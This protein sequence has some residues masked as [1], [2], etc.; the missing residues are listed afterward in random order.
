MRRK[1]AFPLLI[2]LAVVSGLAPF[3]MAVL[4]PLLPG[5]IV[6]FG[7]DHAT[8]QFVV[9][10]YLLGL[11]LAQPVAGFLC[12]L[13][14]R[15]IVVLVGMGIFVFASIACAFAESVAM[16]ISLRFMQAIG[17]STGTVV[18]RAVI[19]DTHDA[20]VGGRAMSYLTIG[21]GLAPVV[22]PMLS[23]LMYMVGGFRLVFAATASVGVVVW[24][25]LW[26]HLPETR[27]PELPKPR[28]QAWLASY[29]QLL[30]SP[31]FMG[32]TL[33][34]GFIQGSFFAFLAVGAAI[35]E[36]SFGLGPTVFGFV[37]GC[38]A[39]AYVLGAAI[40]GRLSAGRHA[41]LL[42][43]TGILATLV[44][45]VSLPATTAVYGTSP[46]TVLPQMFALM[47][48][49]GA[50]TPVVIAGAV[51]HHPEAAG[52]S[53]GLSSAL[54]IVVSAVFA[55]L[56]G[57]VFT[58]DFAPVAAIIAISASL[59]FVSWLLVRKTASI[60]AHAAEERQRSAG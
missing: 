6:H 21:L 33:T 9:S 19:H 30:G 24:V 53:A 11:A 34:F 39:V 45:G 26:L 16:L 55:V 31:V 56:S 8:V 32:Y 42:L 44:V 37:G 25:L 14:G 36:T 38:M 3:A 18:S 59:T 2:L 48:L 10:A 41:S 57:A 15:R 5:L 23:G 17:I 22:A 20:T 49:A 60:D 29:G 4:L 7:S 51:Y 43:P 28:W 27:P 47:A 58:G 50:V 54:G 40:G 12:D 1:P 35:F 13:F 52:T 46:G